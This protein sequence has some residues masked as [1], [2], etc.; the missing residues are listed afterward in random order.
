[1]ASTASMSL[2]G[3]GVLGERRGHTRGAR[4]ALGQGAGAGLDQQA[5]GVAVVAAF[6]LD[7]AVATGETTGQA[8]G[9]HG[10]FGAGA[11]HAYHFHRRYERAHQISHLGF[12]LGRRAVGQAVFKLLA[13]RVQDVRVAVAEDHRAP[14]T[15]VI[16]ITLVVFVGDVGAFSVLEEQRRAANA[17]E[18]A[19]RRVHTTGNV[20]LGI[21]KQRFGTRHDRA[22]KSDFQ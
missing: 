18:R 15:D 12:H 16:D 10:R 9:A 22:L 17:L 14:R 7:D 2:K 4:H 5:V 3:Q 8:N 1:M 6:E 11:D 19:N 13:H 20:F 21:G